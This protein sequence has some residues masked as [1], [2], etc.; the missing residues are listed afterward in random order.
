[1]GNEE[2][3]KRH[4]LYGS[5]GMAAA[6]MIRTGSNPARPSGKET[7]RESAEETPEDGVEITETPEGAIEIVQI[8]EELATEPTPVIPL[9]ELSAPEPEPEPAPVPH[10]VRA[11]VIGHTGAGNYGHGLDFLFHRLDN[12]R[13]V[14]IADADPAGLDAAQLR[15][16]AEGPYADYHAMLEAEKPQLVAVAPRQTGERF[17]MVKAALEAGAHVCC[18]RPL[19]RTLREADELVALAAGKGLRIAVLNPMR[20]DPN[21]RRFHAE[22]SDLIG[23]LIELKVFGMMDHRAGGEDLLVLGNHLFDLVRL[24]AGEPNYCTAVITREGEPALADEPHYSEKEDLGPLLGDVIHAEF[25][26]ESGVHVSYVSDQRLHRLHGPWGIEF[27]GEKGRAR[28]FAGQPPTLSLLVEDSVDSPDRV[29]RWQRWP[30]V[31]EGE[32]YH[33]PVGHLSGND[34]ANRLVVQDWLAAIAEER[35]PVCSADNALK[36]L[37]MIHGVWQAGATMKRA[38][39][40]LANRLHPL[41]EDPS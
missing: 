27:I 12:V 21:V 10:W 2:K 35:D 39:F 32:P 9:E 36:A 25:V 22:Y 18:E 5:A 20:L 23:G 4:A 6:G 1:M 7:T 14:A 29:T 26:M 38:Y 40:P 8:G 19:A 15:T 30:A 41:A 37:E 33:A 34:G 31:G 24:F 11:A 16:G 17:A 13:L 3:G 28:L